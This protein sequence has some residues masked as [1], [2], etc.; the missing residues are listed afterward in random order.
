MGRILVVAMN[1]VSATRGPTTPDLA[2]GGQT[3]PGP[4]TPGPTTPGRTKGRITNG[5]YAAVVAATAEFGLCPWSDAEIGSGLGVTSTSVGGAVT[6]LRALGRLHDVVRA[7][8]DDDPRFAGHELRRGGM[9]LAPADAVPVPTGARGSLE[10][11]EAQRLREEAAAQQRCQRA[12]AEARKTFH[13]EI[14]IIRARATIARR[15][16][17]NQG[18]ASSATM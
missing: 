3:T 1:D 10:Q 9:A 16:I 17:L 4:T 18:G 5:V 14:Q 13:D 2:P 12:L 15:E 7:I 11:L 8:P 6:R